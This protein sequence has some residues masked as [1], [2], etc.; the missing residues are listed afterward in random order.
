[1]HA[2]VTS[3]DRP[4]YYRQNVTLPEID[5]RKKKNEELE[6]HLVIG[7]QCSEWQ[8]VTFSFDKRK[9]SF[10]T[11]RDTSLRTRSLLK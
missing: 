4:N 10:T 9:E 5:T 1:M 6:V 11:S 2:I 3:S 7:R 8:T